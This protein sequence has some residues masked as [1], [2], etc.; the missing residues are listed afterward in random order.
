MRKVAR[1]HGSQLF[2]SPLIGYNSNMS[3]CQGLVVRIRCE[4]DFLKVASHDGNRSEQSNQP[5]MI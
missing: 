3:I 1:V 4:W 2:S 5:E